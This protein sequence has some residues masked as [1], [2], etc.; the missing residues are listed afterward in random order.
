MLVQLYM[1]SRAINSITLSRALST[2]ACQTLI[3]I[4]AAYSN[5]KPGLYTKLSFL[6]QRFHFL[7]TQKFH[8]LTELVKWLV[9]LILPTYFSALKRTTV[10]YHLLSVDDLC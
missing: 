3:P 8:F 6:R 5:R 1:I 7:I 10:Q 9:L 4:N 2:C